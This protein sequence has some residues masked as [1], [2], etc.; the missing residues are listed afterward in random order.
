MEDDYERIEEAVRGCDLPLKVKAKVLGSVR[1]T[2]DDHVRQ[3]S[4]GQEGLFDNCIDNPLFERGFD[5]L[6]EPGTSY[7]EAVVLYD[8]MK[9]ALISY[10][11]E[12][13]Y[14]VETE[15]PVNIAK[16]M[17]ERKLANFFWGECVNINAK[18]GKEEWYVQFSIETFIHN[19]G[20]MGSFSVYPRW[21]PPELKKL[22]QEV[23][24]S[25]QPK[26]DDEEILKKYHR[27]GDPENCTH[28]GKAEMNPPRFDIPY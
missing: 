25:V 7:W 4:K 10:A 23:S 8:R 6:P 22:L 17:C 20:L 19:S 16:A 13:G 14:E 3:C 5:D 21:S 11:E 24:E 15:F 27:T 12:R 1:S 9:E 28:C 18:K 26:P 2:L